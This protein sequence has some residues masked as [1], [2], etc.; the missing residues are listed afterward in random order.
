[1]PV[2][3]PSIASRT[4]PHLRAVTQHFPRPR[5]PDPYAGAY[6]A[7]AA[8]LQT[9]QARPGA[10]IAIGVGSRGI[11]DI[12]PVVRATVAAC[13]DAGLAPFVAPAMGSH[14]GGT[15]TG[16]LAVLEH[17]GVTAAN[18]GAEIVAESAVEQIGVTHWGMPVYFD[19]AALAAD[20]VVPVNRIKP[21]TDFAGTHESGLCKML[22]IGFA[23]HEG[24]ARV[25]QEGFA[26]FHTVVPETA[27]LILERVPVAFGIAVVENAY[28]ETYLVE[29][30]PGAHILAREAELLQIAYAHMP[31]L[32]F[33]HIDVLI[34]DEI[35][36][37][38][39]GAGMD[40][41]IVGRTATGILAG[42]RGPA[43]MRIVV[44]GLSAA[45]GGNAIGIGAADF[46]T[47]ALAAEYDPEATYAN[48]IASGTPESA[49]L[50]I[51]LPT[52]ADA[53][54]A[55]LLTSGVNDW[56]RAAIVRIQNTLH[57]ETVWVSGALAAALLNAVGSRHHPAAPASA[58]PGPIGSPAVAGA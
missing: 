33:D 15:A 14:G 52:P 51:V 31:R 27:A 37:N 1:M 5:H 26:R 47:A 19:K 38:I 39:S 42:Y 58:V 20:Y 24:C 9:I 16:Q 13:R 46:T 17:L 3:P 43:I 53:V 7:A 48:A 2:L 23:N 57:L 25:H 56:E 54:R 21:H 55:A 6:A 4:L 18:I 12:V 10:T 49:R 32:G 11:R 34:V 41:N 50:P 30:I 36:K 8:Q 35:G 45:S 22:V 44:S 29:A 28:D 40:P